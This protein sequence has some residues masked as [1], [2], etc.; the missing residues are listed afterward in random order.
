VERSKWLKF[1]MAVLLPLVLLLFV[2]F[3]RTPKAVSEPD[4]RLSDPG[5]L[6][7]V[8]SQPDHAAG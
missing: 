6:A 2:I 8:S 7:R 4:R 5:P 3:G 1:V